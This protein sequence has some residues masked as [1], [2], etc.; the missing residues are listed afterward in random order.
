[1]M[2]AW[3]LPQASPVAV[4]PCCVDLEVFSPPAS[5]PAKAFALAYLGSIGTWYMLDEMLLFLPACEG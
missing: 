3:H 1:M 5:P 4:I 2:A